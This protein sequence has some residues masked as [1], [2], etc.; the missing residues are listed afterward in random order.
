[1][2]KRKLIQ[3]LLKELG[4]KFS[5]ALGIDLKNSTS[6]EVFKWF[7]ASILFGA[8]ISETI[9]VKTYK[10]FERRKVLSPDSILQTGW[11]GL[12]EILDA[13][14][15]VRYDFKTATK[16]LDIMKNLKDR[17]NGDLNLLHKESRDSRDLEV[18][19]QSLG[20]GI[21]EVT[22]NIF[23][24]ELRGV[25][26]KAEPYPSD[27]VILAARRSGLIS[28]KINSKEK[29]LEE[30]KTL[31]QKYKVKGKDYIAFEAALL[32][33][34]KDYYRKGKTQPF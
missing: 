26:E 13:G 16:L 25:W 15:Y 1:M 31:W 19:L 22:T 3:T 12:V 24:R 32:R 8:R 21:G 30:L 17:Y 23:F 34:G 29:I 2:N 14:G 20:K 10:E 9:A 4:V 33:L 28:S 27:L 7:L 5:T 18:N 6:E 11:D